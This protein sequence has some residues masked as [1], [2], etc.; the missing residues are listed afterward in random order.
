LV[1]RELGI[2]LGDQDR[3]EIFGTDD[4][5]AHLE[6]AY[7]HRD[8]VQPLRE[9]IIASAVRGL[10]AMGEVGS[11]L[12]DRLQALAQDTSP[13]SVDHKKIVGG[14]IN[15][16]VGIDHAH[17]GGMGISLQWHDDRRALQRA[18]LHESIA[19]NI[20][21]DPQAVH[22]LAD[23][24]AYALVDGNA[25]DRAEAKTRLNDLASERLRLGTKA[26]WHMSQAERDRHKDERDFAHHIGD[27]SSNRR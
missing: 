14:R 15:A 27:R 25:Q 3:R 21:G 7:S 4:D 6:R 20:F 12:A 13:T 9:K 26:L 1:Q 24:V 17:A 18:L 10:A 23:A 5:D 22:S 19:G 16:V 11:E 2:F 8:G